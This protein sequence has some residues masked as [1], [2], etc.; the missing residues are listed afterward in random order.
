MS[1]SRLAG[2]ANALNVLPS[3]SQWP[4]L[5][6]VNASLVYVIGDSLF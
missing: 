3:V 2:G 5:Q 1:C 4:N 6:T